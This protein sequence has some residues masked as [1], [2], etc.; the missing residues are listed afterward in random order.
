MT[1]FST[2]IYHGKEYSISEL[3]KRSKKEPR[4]IR[5]RLYKG[6]GINDAVNVERRD[7]TKHRAL[8]ITKKEHTA[9]QRSFIGESICV[10]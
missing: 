2:V 10:Y 8:Q 5:E 7:T 1:K 3:A 9:L 4:L 6:W